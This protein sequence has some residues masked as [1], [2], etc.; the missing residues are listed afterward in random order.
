MSKAIVSDTSPLISL[1]KISGGFN[2][3]RKLYDKVFIPPAVLEELSKG[4]FSDPVKYL[5][6]YKIEELVEVKP[7]S[8][9]S[10]IPDIDRLDEGEKQAISLAYQLNLPLLIEET[11]GRRIALSAGIHISGIAGQIVKA[12]REKIIERTGA[13]HK[14]KELFQ[15]GRISKKLYDALSVALERS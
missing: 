11:M 8:T 2:F 14:L 4:S 9:I 6:K 1:E 3:I 12:Y 5:K 7:V 15:S 10:E 13:T